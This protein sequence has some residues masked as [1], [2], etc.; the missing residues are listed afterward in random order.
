MEIEEESNLM[1]GSCLVYGNIRQK[2]GDL[3]MEDDLV[4]FFSDVLEERE[5]LDDEERNPGGADDATD[6]ASGGSQPPPASL[7][8]T[9]QFGAHQPSY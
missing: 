5:R 3:K 8:P 9:S 4:S 1:K 6:G 7:G 2:Y